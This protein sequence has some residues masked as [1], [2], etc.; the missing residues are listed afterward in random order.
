MLS[1]K[2]VIIFILFLF[3][4]MPVKVCI[5]QDLTETE[6]SQTDDSSLKDKKSERK[7]EKKEI[8]ID[9]TFFVSLGMDLVTVVLI[10]ILI[11]HPNYRKMDYIFT[12]IAF[13]LVIFLLTFVL[14]SVK[15]SM[16]AVFGLFAVFTMLRYRTAG[17]SMT[18]MTY[19]F[20]FIAMGLIG[21]IELQYYELAI[22]YGVIFLGIFILDSRMV[23][24]R[25]FCKTIQ[26]EKIELIKPELY[27]ELMEDLKTR[28]GLDI[29]RVTVSRI[30]FLRDTARL[31]IY[32]YESE[33]NGNKKA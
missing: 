8:E 7:K 6:L 18:D 20:I 19:L 22:I 16:G 12:F 25:E 1:A 27:D 14:K 30:N 26:Y 3:L 23:I 15:I 31:N 28:T 2:N 4:A 17:I 29:K 21:A 10:I 5:P 13:N 32:Y 24:K 9:S 11:Y 33:K